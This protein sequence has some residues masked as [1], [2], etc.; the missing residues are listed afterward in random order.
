MRRLT[1]VRHGATAWNAQGRFQGQNDVALSELGREQARALAQRFEGVAFDRIVSSDLARAAET[2]R[3]IA[4]ER[5]VVCDE[6]W[7]EFAFGAWEG[8]TWREIGERYPEC[9]A[10]D[11]TAVRGYTPPGGE[12]FVAVRARVAEA[13]AE[14]RRSGCDAPLVVSHAGTIHAALDLLLA[15]P[16]RVKLAPAAIVTVLFENGDQAKSSVNISTVSTS[17][18]PGRLT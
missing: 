3:T 10:L 5:P 18:G 17:L 7:R 2:A 8:L 16:P 12:T 14:L 6:R 9:A 15:Q 4:G 1:L 13:L 11:V